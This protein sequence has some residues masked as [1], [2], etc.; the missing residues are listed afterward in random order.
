MGGPLVACQGV[1]PTWWARAHYYSSPHPRASRCP[2]ARYREVRR[3]AVS[4][5]RARRSAGFRWVEPNRARPDPGPCEGVKSDE[6][7]THSAGPPQEESTPSVY[8]YK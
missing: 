8:G 1:D 7:Q 5:R 2:A 4:R 3:P 6:P